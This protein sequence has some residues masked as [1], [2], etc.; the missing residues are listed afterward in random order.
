MFASI[1]KFIISP[2][3]LI[4]ISFLIILVYIFSKGT[5]FLSLKKVFNGYSEVFEEAK[6]HQLVFWGVPILLAVALTRVALITNDLTNNLLV[7]LSILIS[8][9]FAMLAVLVNIQANKHDAT[10][11]Q[12]YKQTV[13]VVLVEIVVCVCALIITLSLLVFSGEALKWVVI[14]ASF[15]D[16]YLVF[17]MI[18]NLLI[19]IKRIK[20]FVDNI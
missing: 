5:N 17:V 15:L 3:F 11:Q 18:L 7:F 20:A 9:F 2:A 4:G 19:L 8:S 1:L 10:Y 12:V 14:I 16:Y 6:H 13:S